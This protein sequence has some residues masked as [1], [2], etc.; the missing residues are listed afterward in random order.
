MAVVAVFNQKGGVSKATTCLNLTAAL[1]LTQR[2]P[3]ALD[4]DPQGHLSLASGLKHGTTQTS[5]A[6]YCFLL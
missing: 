5:N 4:M 3:I 1:S 2:S 6:Q